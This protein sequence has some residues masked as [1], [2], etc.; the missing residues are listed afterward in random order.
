M[1]PREP[2]GKW[3]EAIAA[4][5]KANEAWDRTIRV[6]RQIS[7]LVKLLGG[8]LGLILGAI[9]GFSLYSWY[10]LV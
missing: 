2:N 1:E 7:F 10:Y 9:L 5:A 4:W 3:E 8:F 6:Q